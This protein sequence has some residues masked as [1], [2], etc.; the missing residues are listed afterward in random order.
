MGGRGAYLESGGFSIQGW[1]QVG[2]IEGV[3]VLKKI[4]TKKGSKGN[5]PF[6]SDKPGIA[7]ILLDEDGKFSQFRQY[8]EDRRPEFDIDYGYH[9]GKISLH[10]HEFGS[11]GRS[12]NPKIIAYP[13]GDIIDKKLYEKYKTFLKG[14]DL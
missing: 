7:Y 14:I 2:T 4:G 11:D 3:K 5:L 1:K 6:Y 13:N 10:L 9:N 8:G 12:K